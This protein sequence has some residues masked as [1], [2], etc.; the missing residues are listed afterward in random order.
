MLF[1]NFGIFM[2]LIA[3][4]LI[5]SIHVASFTKDDEGAILLCNE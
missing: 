5:Q 4:E 2:F 1:Y 3:P